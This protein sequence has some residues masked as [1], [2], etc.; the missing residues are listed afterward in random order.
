MR[1][2]GNGDKSIKRFQLIPYKWLILVDAIVVTAAV[3]SFGM[4]ATFCMGLR[5]DN[6][7]LM[8]A[9]IPP[10]VIA[11]DLT[12]FITI[13]AIRRRTVPLLNAIQQVADGDLNTELDTK[14]AGEYVSI[15]ES[16]N[17]M[18]RELK[19]TKE[20]M[21][22]FLNE[23]SHEF[24][25]PITAIRG[26]SEY[27]V[28]TGAGIETP[29]RV[30]YLQ[31]I[32]D[33]SGRLAEL[34]QNMLF[35]SKVEAT[36]IVTDKTS[37]DLGEQV[38]QCVI[39]LLPQIEKKDI[40]LEIALPDEIAYYGDPELMEQIWINLLNNAVKF[41]PEQG[42][43]S[44]SGQ[45]MEDGLTVSISDNGMGMEDETRKHIFEKYYQS[46]RRKGGNGIGLSIVHR[47]VTLCGGTVT[48]DSAPGEGSTFTVFLPK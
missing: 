13:R 15:Y 39:L 16:F 25:T 34:S 20:E 14:N 24:K 32:R 37:F 35:L 19:G 21:Q 26:F 40:S 22:N 23:Y 18:T 4:V 46:D 28:D 41:T 27:L 47:I 9:V 36:Q 43:I 6:A 17:R 10:M 45:I 42:E 8:L 5:E 31:M 44:I 48:V 30:K 33:E 12:T 11:T 1:A 38:K 7:L 3:M 29:E 2:N